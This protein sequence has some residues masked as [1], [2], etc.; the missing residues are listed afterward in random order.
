MVTESKDLPTSK[1]VTAL[2]PNKV[3]R[4]LTNDYL[5]QGKD[6]YTAL[7]HKKPYEFGLTDAQVLTNYL[8]RHDS[9]PLLKP[10]YLML[11]QVFRP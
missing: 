1:T 11:E 6:G 4:V 7:K 9:L 5:I 10:N 3:Y 2:E 8:K